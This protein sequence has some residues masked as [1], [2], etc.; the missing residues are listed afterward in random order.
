MPAWPGDG[1]RARCPGS[2]LSGLAACPPARRSP[3]RSSGPPAGRGPR[4]RREASVVLEQPRKCCGRTAPPL[5]APWVL[6][7]DA[8]SCRGPCRAQLGPA[9]SAWPR[10]LP[11]RL[12][13]PW[14][15][16][17]PAF[18]LRGRAECGGQERP[19]D[20]CRPWKFRP[21]GRP[22]GS[23]CAQAG[24]RE[25]SAEVAWAGPVVRRFQGD[26]PG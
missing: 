6:T 10:P 24:P 12:A 18:T 7:G 4:G 15:A 9:L 22:A 26:L 23:R 21:R 11:G 19:R 14:C 3:A 8:G 17:R 25:V 16:A 2:S 20:D 13:V 5:P 1:R